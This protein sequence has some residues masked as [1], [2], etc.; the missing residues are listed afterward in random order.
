MREPQRAAIPGR[1]VAARRGDQVQRGAVAVG[2]VPALAG[3]A[4]A[5]PVGAQDPQRVGQ[6]PRVDLLARVAGRH[7]PR[8]QRGEAA[9]RAD[10]D[11]PVEL[12]RTARDSRRAATVAG[13]DRAGRA[14]APDRERIAVLEPDVQVLDV[15]RVPRQ[16]DPLPGPHALAGVHEHADHVRVEDLVARDPQ[17]DVEPADDAAA[18]RRRRPARIHHGGVSDGEHRCAGRDGDVDRVVGLPVAKRPALM[19]GR[20]GDHRAAAG[21]RVP[22]PPGARAGGRPVVDRSPVEDGEVAPR[23]RACVREH[24][25]DVGLGV[26]VGEDRVVQVAI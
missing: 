8:R 4:D 14:V 7:R 13:R 10:G 6:D 5:Q 2:V 23:V 25:L 17:R 11:G 26:V 19:I 24:V 9:R 18:V 20:G 22:K 16:P 15:V 21:Q 3:R 1:L 12:G